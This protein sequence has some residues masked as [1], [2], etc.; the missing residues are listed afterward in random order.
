MQKINKKTIFFLLLIFVLAALTKYLQYNVLPEKYFKDSSFIL[1]LMDGNYVADKTYNMTAF[2][3][4]KIN[5]LKFYSLQQWSI[6]FAVI[7]NFIIVYILYKSKKNY[8]LSQYFFIYASTILLNIY[9]FNLS[10]DIIQFCVFLL[11]YLILINP[12]MNNQNKL[13]SILTIL[14]L[15]AFMYR[16]YYGIMAFVLLTIYI[17]Y[18]VFIRNRNLNKNNIIKIIF[19][20]LFF[21]F[22]EVFFISLISKENYNTIILARSNINMYREFDTNAATII[23]EP[24]GINDTFSKFIGNYSLNFLRIA[25]P[26]ELFF[27]GIIYIPF[28]FYQLY[29]IY[30]FIKTLKKINDK[31]I[32]LVATFLSYFM[33]SVI[34]EPDFGSFIRHESAMALILI[35]LSNESISKKLK[36]KRKSD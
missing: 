14:V 31:N 4:D 28:V 20:C 34:F 5:F 7:F 15:E 35:A 22:M 16:I 1:T 6:F 3:F 2:I 8:K 32:L 11:I 23:N 25:F 29:I 30:V 27:K 12:K 24:L 33:I 10:K 19:L 17:I 18:L 26:I 36:E 13:I 9:V 21:F